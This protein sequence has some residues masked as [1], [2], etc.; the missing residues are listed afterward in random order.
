MVAN[1]IIMTREEFIDK[2]AD[3]LE[4]D[5]LLFADGFDDALV[6]LDM[7]NVKVIYD[8]NKM[9]DILVDDGMSII[10]A[11]EHLDYNVINAYV[12]EKTPI[13]FI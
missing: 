4:D 9:L 3:Y 5:N 11:I 8:Y 12:G 13:Y 7:V 10:D 6:G 1:Q 2:Y